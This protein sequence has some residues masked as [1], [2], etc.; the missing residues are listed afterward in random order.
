MNLDIAYFLLLLVFIANILCYHV[1]N[2]DC[3]NKVDSIDKFSDKEKRLNQRLDPLKGEQFTAKEVR[4]NKDEY[5]Y[6]LGICAEATSPD[7]KLRPNAGMIQLKKGDKEPKV[8]GLY[9]QTELLGGDNWILLKYKGGD[10]YHHCKDINN[11]SQP[12][13]TL[14]MITCGPPLK[15]ELTLLEENIG[16]QEECYY[17][18]QFES[19]VACTPQDGLS[20]GSIFCI[21]LLTSVGL[22]LL[23]GF[24]HQRIVVGAKGLEQIP[25]YNMWKEFG[26][27]QADGCDFLCRCGE[28]QEAKMYR[29]ID[30]QLLNP[31]ARDDRDERL[32]PM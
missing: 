21:I 24:L 18:F 2:G 20:A 6:F 23:I 31:E 12:R 28:R 25:N 22:Y 11:K 13:Q 9:N 14:V 26:K 15:G 7:K 10:P 17:L 3:S 1:I 32:L 8:L 4:E 30:D 5:D 27:L 19:N 16:E 29:G